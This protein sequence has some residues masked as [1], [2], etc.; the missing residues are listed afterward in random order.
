[1]V[2]AA[3]IG[4]NAFGIRDSLMGSA[5]PSAKPVAVSPFHSVQGDRHT[6]KT[7]LR[8][9]PWWQGV[10]RLTG[11][12]GTS[13]RSVKVDASAA[14]WRA[15]WSCESGHLTARFGGTEPLVDA[16]C[17]GHGTA[18]SN[19]NGA[20]RLAITAA[21]PWTLDVEQQVDVPL[22]EP[23]LP[24]MA[25]ATTSVAFTG[26][27]YRVDQ[28]GQGRLTIYR[29]ALGKYVMRLANFY[30]TPN[31]DLE[32][33]FTR[34]RSPITTKAFMRAPSIVVAP[35]NVTAGSLNF[36]LPKG[37]NPA[38]Y[39]SAVIWCPLINSAYSAAPLARRP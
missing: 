21:G 24:S 28:A 1:M 6:P 5:T 16:A 20:L 30:T 9:Q 3:L 33:R 22:V 26:G 25:A 10:A 11:G 29:L 37:L 15:R 31:I 12:A 19:R 18:L 4:G 35:L 17:P 14:Q 32:V 7:V 2:A 36:A 39:R 38:R 23:P 27:F 34:L 13:G 8:S